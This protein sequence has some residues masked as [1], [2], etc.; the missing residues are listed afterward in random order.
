MGNK[1]ALWREQKPLLCVQ[2]RDLLLTDK[3]SVVSEDRK[4]VASADKKSV[5]F[6]DKPSVVS[7]DKKSLDCQDIPMAEVCRWADGWVG[8]GRV[9]GWRAGSSGGHACM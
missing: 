9:C 7:A 8:N 6:A 1:C 3:T 2:R 4:S 5:V